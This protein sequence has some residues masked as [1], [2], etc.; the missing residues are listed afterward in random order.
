MGKKKEVSLDNVW[1]ERSYFF[2]CPICNEVIEN[3]SEIGIG[4]E[5]F[6]DNCTNTLKVVS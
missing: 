1:E 2:E 3:D 6:C 4:D 5:V